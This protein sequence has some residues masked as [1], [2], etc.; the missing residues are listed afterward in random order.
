M[1]ARSNEYIITSNLEVHNSA[2]V[3]L[4]KTDV[5]V[6]TNNDVVMMVVAKAIGALH[7][8]AIT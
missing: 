5:I 7:S 3:N 6:V 2:L 4:G 1:Y 8:V